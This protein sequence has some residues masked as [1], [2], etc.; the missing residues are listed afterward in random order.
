M[1]VSKYG[2]ATQPLYL[3]TVVRRV[4]KDQ[5]FL[6]SKNMH[7]IN[8]DEAV[9]VSGGEE[10]TFE[11]IPKKFTIMDVG[12]GETMSGDDTKHTLLYLYDNPQPN[13][14]NIAILFDWLTYL[15]ALSPNDPITTK[16]TKTAHAALDT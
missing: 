2:E 4:G 3:S 15:P 5:V 10:Y 6:G 12:F 11:L 8:L 16:M 14:E 9:H 13:A 7:I 1:Q